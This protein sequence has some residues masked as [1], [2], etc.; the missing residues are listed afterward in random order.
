MVNFE[1]ILKSIDEAVYKCGGS[2]RLKRI[3]A[4]VKVT[5]EDGFETYHYDNGMSITFDLGINENGRGEYSLDN[6]IVGDEKIS[7]LGEEAY[8]FFKEQKDFI[9]ETFGYKGW[10]DFTRYVY[11]FSL[12]RAFELNSMLRT[13]FEKELKE[14]SKLSGRKETG[15]WM[16]ENHP[17]FVEIMDS[18]P[19]P[20]E[21]FITL[22]VVNKL[23]DN[24]SL[25]RR[26]VK[27]KGHTSSSCGSPM[28]K[29]EDYGDLEDGAWKIITV[30]HPDDE[31]HGAFLGTAFKESS[32]GYDYE[33]EFNYLPNQ[34]FV[35]DVIDEK[36]HII[37]QHPK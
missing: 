1:F 27:D 6:I 8:D 12:G 13:D 30:V 19:L 33:L 16:W 36:N 4:S 7:Y 24:D 37:I 17:Q 5:Q 10:D 20:D 9:G 34:K 28:T 25:N 18:V 26:I 22:R 31:V 29:L 15:G 21:S 11:N 14:W 32:C 2:E 23:H 3:G 35:R